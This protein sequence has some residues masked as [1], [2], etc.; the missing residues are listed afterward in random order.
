[1]RDQGGGW[2]A[3][4]M[5]ERLE[6]R[7]LLAELPPV[8]PAQVAA[9][10]GPAEGSGVLR[11]REGE[12][13]TARGLWGVVVEAEHWKGR[14][15]ALLS[16]GLGEPTGL[17]ATRY[18]LLLEW[19]EGGGA[20]RVIDAARFVARPSGFGGVEW[21]GVFLPVLLVCLLLTLGLT[22]GWRSR[23]RHDDGSTAAPAEATQG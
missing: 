18:E 3:G 4:R 10:L 23:R 11:T 1:M 14:R 22:L 16:L 2:V 17:P 5:L 7:K 8:E 15:R 20:P 19:P 9:L 13:A 6:R 21:P 12:A